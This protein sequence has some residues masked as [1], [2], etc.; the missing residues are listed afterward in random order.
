MG[1]KVP[2]EYIYFAFAFSIFVETM[3]TLAS[4]RRKRRLQQQAQKGE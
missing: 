2:K 3:N 4:R 1:V